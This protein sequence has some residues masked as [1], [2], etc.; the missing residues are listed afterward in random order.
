MQALRKDK[1]CSKQFPSISALE[2]P[3]SLSLS[4]DSINVALEKWMSEW[5]FPCRLPPLL[6]LETGSPNR[7]AHKKT[8]PLHAVDVQD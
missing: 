5:P 1:G 3:A 4:V 8:H 6:L 2:T 7:T